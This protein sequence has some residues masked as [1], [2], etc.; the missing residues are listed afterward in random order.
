MNKQEIA[1][2]LRA[3]VGALEDLIKK[4]KARSDRL[5]RMVLELE[6]ETAGPAAQAEI[7]MLGPGSKFQKMVDRVF[8]E[9]PKRPKR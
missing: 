7:K 2:T 9:P 1:E 3:E 4:L 8:G 5:K 6:E